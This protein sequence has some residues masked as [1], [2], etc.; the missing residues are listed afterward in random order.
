MEFRK[1]HFNL[2]IFFVRELEEKTLSC[3]GTAQK[4]IKLELQDL[5]ERLKISKDSLQR[6]RE[7]LDE[8]EDD[9]AE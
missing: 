3:I 6:L 5:S 4:K 9:E 8:L 2:L 7:Q 1:V